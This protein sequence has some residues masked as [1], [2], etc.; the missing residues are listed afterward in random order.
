MTSYPVGSV[1]WS[2]SGNPPYAEYPIPFTQDVVSGNIIF[3]APTFKIAGNHV[4]SDV[5]VMVAVNVGALSATQ[6]VTGYQ[7]TCY[8][9]EGVQQTLTVMCDAWRDPANSVG[10]LAY[11]QDLLDSVKDTIVEGA[12][13]YRGLYIPALV[14]GQALSITGSTYATGWEGLKI[15]VLEVELTWNSG[16]PTLYTTVMQVSNRRAHYT[17][18]AF[19]R[20]DRPI[21]GSIVQGLEGVG[22]SAAGAAYAAKVAALPKPL[23]PEQAQARANVATEKNKAAAQRAP[24]ESAMAGFGSVE[25]ASAG[26]FDRPA[27]IASVSEFAGADA[28]EQFADV[29][30]LITGE[31]EV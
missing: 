12:V 27:N 3:Q 1:L 26:S 29:T 17:T 23:T 18:G 8:S 10:M 28:A 24:E 21:G 13:T 4:P 20:P 9:V 25:D 15:P 2:Q 30:N 22:A 7:G 5:R 14:F 19:L 16:A 6:P 11:A 31:G